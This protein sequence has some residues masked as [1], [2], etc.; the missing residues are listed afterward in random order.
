M[1]EVDPKKFK[2]MIEGKK[3]TF[4]KDFNK[5][6][7]IVLCLKCGYPVMFYGAWVL[8]CD[9]CNSKKNKIYNIEDLQDFIL[10]QQSI[11]YKK[12]RK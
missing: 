12:M 6:A 1:K 11:I 5:G 2:K 9:I 10:K 3:I 8:D 7:R 4:H